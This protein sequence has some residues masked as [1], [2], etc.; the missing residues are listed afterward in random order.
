MEQQQRRP[1]ILSPEAKQFESALLRRAE[2]LQSESLQHGE[3]TFARLI[4]N[5]MSLEFR[6]L[7]KELSLDS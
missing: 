5:R 1:R 4:S 7:A 3:G 6:K 2:A